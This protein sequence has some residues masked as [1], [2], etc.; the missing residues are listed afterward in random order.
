MS[1]MF[2]LGPWENYFHF[3]RLSLL[4]VKWALLGRSPQGVLRIQG[5]SVLSRLSAAPH[6]PVKV[7]ISF[8]QEK[9][10]FLGTAVNQNERIVLIVYP[11]II[12]PVSC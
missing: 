10:Q 12:H 9:N 8:T 2:S 7:S 11:T 5:V 1:K 4:I 3:W 6:R